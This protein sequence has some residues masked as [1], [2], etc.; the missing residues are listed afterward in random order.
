MILDA[1]AYIEALARR[2]LL[3]EGA[4]LAEHN[5]GVWREYLARYADF[6]APLDDITVLMT[7]SGLG[8]Y[9]DPLNDTGLHEWA[10]LGPISHGLLPWSAREL[11]AGI[12]ELPACFAEAGLGP[13]RVRTDT[14]TCAGPIDPSLARHFLWIR[15]PR[16]RGFGDFERYLASLTHDRRKDLRAMIRRFDSLESLRLEL[17]G[18]PPDA[19]ETRLI[20]DHAHARW[21]ADAP[22]AVAQW[23]WPMAIASALPEKVWFMRVFWQGSLALLAA[24]VL[25]GEVAICQATCRLDTE[26]L[27][28]IGG[29]VDAALLR[30]LGAGPVQVVD[31]T[32]RTGVEDTPNIWVS[33]RR[34]VNED[35]EW[36]TLLVQSEAPV[37][38]E[39]D[40]VAP[41]F[42]PD[43]G[44]I[45][46][47][48]RAVIGRPA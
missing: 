28:G 9:E 23:A 46:P 40:G 38:P 39:L 43:R 48:D 15:S 35:M 18:R 3:A 29:F 19:A 25:R 16:A 7:P 4:G 20:L 24:Y 1:A 26:S 11:M 27:P 8:L 47:A 31:P 14:F 36:P 41:Y 5:L 45:L 2:G 21:Q 37:I 34:L 12:A 42:H 44:W 30:Q 22:Y 32:C 6:V 33:K 17:S 10:L 13:A